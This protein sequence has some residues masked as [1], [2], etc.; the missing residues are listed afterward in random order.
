MDPN[1]SK[2][3]EVAV[4]KPRFSSVPTGS[5][6]VTSP[7]QMVRHDATHSSFLPA[8]HNSACLAAW[9]KRAFRLGTLL[10][11]RSLSAHNPRGTAR[12]WAAAAGPRLVRLHSA[13]RRRPV[14]QTDPLTNLS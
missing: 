9:A 1:M 14:P 6:I 10:I 11:D 5:N 8:F 12:A 3:S 2:A 13:W 4:S 7:G